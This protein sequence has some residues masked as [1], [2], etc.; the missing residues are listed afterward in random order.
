MSK[1]PMTNPST[2]PWNVPISSTD[3]SKLLNGF[4]P[5]DMDDKWY[6]HADEPDA[7]GNF[8]LHIDRSWTGHEQMALIVQ[9]TR[10]SEIQWVLLREAYGDESDV[11]KFAKSMCRGFLGCDL[12]ALPSNS[13]ED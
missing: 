12:E 6:L 9:P 10:I 11:K 13:A 3:Y 4:R 8:I 1:I 7:Q 2:A 5:Q